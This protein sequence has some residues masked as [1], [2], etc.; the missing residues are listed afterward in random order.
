MSDSREKLFPMLE[1]LQVLSKLKP[2]DKELTAKPFMKRIM[3]CWLPAHEALLEMIVYHLPSPAV[4]QKYRVD[5]LYE[6]GLG[7]VGDRGSARWADLQLS[8]ACGALKLGLCLGYIKA[9]KLLHLDLLFLRNP[10]QE[11]PCELQPGRWLACLLGGVC[12]VIFSP[13]L[14][15]IRW[16]WA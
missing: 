6:V 15:G 11:R 13:A 12:F 7:F 10:A 3:Q 1:K 16:R 2:D 14:A 8:L 9:S 5:T 4:A